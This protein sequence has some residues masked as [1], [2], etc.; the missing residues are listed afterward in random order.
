MCFMIRCLFVFKQK[1][2]KFLISLHCIRRCFLYIFFSLRAIKFNELTIS[3]I[4]FTI[5]LCVHNYFRIQPWKFR[6]TTLFSMLNDFQFDWHNFNFCTTFISGLHFNPCNYQFILNDIKLW[7]VKWHV[8]FSTTH[9]TKH[10]THTIIT[11]AV[12]YTLK[13]GRVCVWHQSNIYSK[14]NNKHSKVRALIKFS[15]E[16]LNVYFCNVLQY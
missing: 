3:F 13:A 4:I 6:K 5:S 15:I 2:L 8:K 16:T 9:I 12:N 1:D 11:C 7:N 14:I 10:K